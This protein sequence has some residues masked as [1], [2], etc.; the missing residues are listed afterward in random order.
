MNTSN[1]CLLGISLTSLNLEPKNEAWAD[2]I[3]AWYRIHGRH[4]L[5]WQK[6]RGPYTCWISEIMLQQTQVTTVIDYF[7]RFMRAFPTVHALAAA[8]LDKVLSLW[9]GLGYYARARH[10]HRA[11]QIITQEWGGLFPRTAAKWQAL[12]GIGQSTAHAILAQAY[13]QPAAILDGNLKR[14]LAR[15][16]GISAP[17]SKASTLTQLWRLAETCLPAHSGCDYAQAMMDLGATLCTQKAPLCTACPISTGCQA[18]RSGAPTQFPGK[19]AKRLKPTQQATFLLYTHQSTIGLIR[20]PAEKIWGGLWC[21]PQGEAPAPLQPQLKAQGGPYKHTFT[22]FYL[23][24]TLCW[25]PLT[26]PQVNLMPELH[27]YLAP[28][29]LQLGLPAPIRSRI[30]DYHAHGF[31]PKTS[32]RAPR[33]RAGTLPG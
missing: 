28:E 24:Y 22:H 32:T 29:A 18:H 9:S 11:A 1:N 30:E 6:E 8:P 15:Y 21:L 16:H 2:A 10:L 5:P 13:N 33:A 19:A 7:E 26:A 23:E 20:R 25:Y 31:L 3:L 4:D 14:V 17:I 12:P 27:W